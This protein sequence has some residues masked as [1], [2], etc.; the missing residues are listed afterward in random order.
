MRASAH[1]ALC[2][3][4]VRFVGDLVAL[5]VAAS[6]GQAEDA[7]ELIDVDYEMLPAVATI[8]DALSGDAPPLF[9]AEPGEE[10]SNVVWRGATSW[11]DVDRAFASADHVI[12]ETFTQHRHTCVPMEC[13]AGLAEYDP[14]SDELTYTMSHQNP[15]ATRM[16]LS[17]ILGH[18]AARLTIRAGDVGGSFG[19]KS[20]PAR[21]DV[22]VCAAAKLLHRPVKWIEDRNENLITAGHARDER[23][24]IEAALARD[25]ELV[26][27]RARFEQDS[28]AYPLLNIPLNLVA[29]IV[30]ALLP[31]TLRLQHYS[32]EGCVV[33]TNK[34]S[35]VAYRGPW[36]VECWV[37]ERLMD[38]IA[39]ELE[40]RPDR[41]A[42]AQL[43]TRRRVSV[44]DAHRRVARVHVDK[45]DARSRG[46]DE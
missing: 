43:P 10:A 22:A 25:G 9:A 18:S 30:R 45:P 4:K 40:P 33:A 32:F 1:G 23:I 13:R 29:I 21:E 8:D 20:H 38:V 39:R 17:T 3:D 19:L 2:I 7:L 41:G 15:H 16:F 37:R 35:Y 24:H 44:H 42:P 11:G 36:E 46:R 26:G 28:G 27:L 34:A 6:R 14:A 5:V 31:G 12:R